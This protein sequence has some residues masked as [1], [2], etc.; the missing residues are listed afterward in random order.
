[1]LIHFIGIIHK[2]IRMSWQIL[3][4]LEILSAVPCWRGLQQSGAARGSLPWPGRQGLPVFSEERNVSLLGGC[5]VYTRPDK[6]LHVFSW[7]AELSLLRRCQVCLKDK[8]LHCYAR[9]ALMLLLQMIFQDLL[10]W[11]GISTRSGRNN[12]KISQ[13]TRLSVKCNCSAC[14]QKMYM[15]AGK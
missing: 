6:Q 13:V 12:R 11:K 3:R 7:R 4:I 10:N 5:V 9:Y 2:N 1:M 15:S 8:S 14:M